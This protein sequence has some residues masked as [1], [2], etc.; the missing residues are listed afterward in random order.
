LDK[1]RKLVIKCDVTKKGNVLVDKVEV[2]DLDGSFY[3]KRSR[4][5]FNINKSC[6]EK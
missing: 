1:T 6:R 3:L 2:I 4:I 5:M